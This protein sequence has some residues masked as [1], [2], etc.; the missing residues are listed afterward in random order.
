MK[1][2]TKDKIMTICLCASLI[3]FG[4]SCIAFILNDWILGIILLVSFIILFTMFIILIEIEDC[5]KQSKEKLEDIKPEDLSKYV[6]LEDLPQV[7]KRLDEDILRNKK[8]NRCSEI[9]FSQ[10]AK[11]ED[12]KQRDYLIKTK[13]LGNLKN[14][15]LIDE[16][17]I[18][19]IGDYFIT[20]EK[21]MTENIKID[22]YN[23]SCDE[24][25]QYCF[26]HLD[27]FIKRLQSYEEKQKILDEYKEEA[28]CKKN[29][30]PS[31]NSKS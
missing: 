27:I 8:L 11:I 13:F 25:E 31:K 16:F 28:L 21:I 22:C 7:L 9:D 23:S 2:E 24:I 15:K 10:Y 26:K 30:E 18:S 19:F 12:L 4:G 14:K 20:L 6:K 1:N 5:P 17:K 29:A 3:G